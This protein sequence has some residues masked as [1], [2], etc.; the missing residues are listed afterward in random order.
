[1]GQLE[2]T[3]RC[4]LPPTSK[5][6]LLSHETLEESP[7][8]PNVVEYQPLKK[9]PQLS[10]LSVNEHRG[11]GEGIPQMELLATVGLCGDLPRSGARHRTEDPFVS[12]TTLSRYLKGFIPPGLF[13][14]ILLPSSL[15]N[16]E[17]AALQ[18]SV[19]AMAKPGCAGQGDSP[20]S[21]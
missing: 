2:A 12:Q 20:K 19:T 3:R 6:E 17:E 14:A 4:S 18:S 11:E 16:R 15:G 8:T 5:K 13:S 21:L 10:R 7:E 1:M 9:P